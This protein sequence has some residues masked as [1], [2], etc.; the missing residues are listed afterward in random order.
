MD[1]NFYGQLR[2]MSAEQYVICLQLPIDEERRARIEKEI[3]YNCLYAAE[4]F[5]KYGNEALARANL[6]MFN[7]YNQKVRITGSHVRFALKEISKQCP[8]LSKDV[9]ACWKTV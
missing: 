8:N 4:G 9:E 5:A 3:C 6:S 7:S 1:G 2:Q